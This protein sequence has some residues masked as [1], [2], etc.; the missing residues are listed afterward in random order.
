MQDIVVESDEVN[1]VEVNT[2]TY[3]QVT[4]N[5]ALKKKSSKRKSL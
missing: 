2:I 3:W 5:F 1:R 4:D